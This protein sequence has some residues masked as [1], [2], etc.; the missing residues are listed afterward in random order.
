[1]VHN[2]ERSR[3][4]AKLM[5][6][7]LLAMSAAMLVNRDAMQQIAAQVAD[8]YAVIFLSGILLLVTGLAAAVWL[9]GSGLFTRLSPSELAD[10]GRLY[11]WRQALV[12]WRDHWLFGTGN[13]SFRFRA[14]SAAPIK[15][16][17]SG[18]SGRQMI[19]ACARGS[20]SC[21]CCVG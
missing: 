4:L 11:T 5:G 16:S 21:V 6:P 14:S 1:M 17:V 7:T 15:P 8:D 13:D 9:R 10:P 19:N 20:R 3:F 12:M 18:V 2:D